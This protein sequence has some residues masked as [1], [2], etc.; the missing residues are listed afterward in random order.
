MSFRVSKSEWRSIEAEKD[1]NAQNMECIP[2]NEGD[3]VQESR[4]QSLVSLLTSS[5]YD[6]FLMLNEHIESVD[7]DSKA[8][9]LAKP[10]GNFLT[11]LFFVTRLLQDNLIQPNI[12]NIGKKHDSFD[13]SKSKILQDVEFWS[14]TA[15]TEISD[16]HLDWYWELLGFMNIL[17][18][19]S[20][21]IL[22]LAN[23]LIS[24]KFLH[25][26]YQVYSLFYCQSR[27]RSKNVTK[28]SLNDL[29]YRSLHDISRGSLWYMVKAMFWHKKIK[30][31]EQPLGKCYYDLRKWAPG[32]FC[33][34]LFST[35]SPICLIFLTVMDV[36]F[37]A[38]LPVLAHQYI[39]FLLIY[40][41]YEDRLDD[42]A[43]LSEANHAE[44]YE[45]IIK[46]KSAVKTQDAMVDATPYGGRSAVFFPSFTTTRSHIFQTHTVLGDVITERYNPATDVFEDVETTNVARNYVSR[47]SIHLQDRTPREKVI[48]GASVRPMFWSRQP[49]PSKNGTPSK[50]LHNKAS[51]TSAPLTPNL[52]PLNGADVSMM[53]NTFGMMNRTGSTNH[54]M[55]I[56][57]S[58]NNSRIRRNST[59]PIKPV[60]YMSAAGL[61]NIHRPV[62]EGDTSI[63][64]SIDGT[65]TELPFEEVVRRGRRTHIDSRF[66]RDAPVGRSSA[67]SSRHS[68]ISPI[69]GGN[70]SFRGDV[71]DTRPPFR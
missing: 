69:K 21:C 45:K 60:G 15:T 58:I 12:H 35:F 17:L 28:R 53:N 39:S 64:F 26:R 54:D 20:C 61:R 5:P 10:I 50:F 47:D 48:N 62:M 52:K 24:Y 2:E 56:S 40:E 44:I 43:C 46:P 51:P 31:P 1:Q 34:A 18:Q 19:F 49:S 63:S 57:R 70:H 29:G 65:H 36:S 67:A 55:C 13:L 42:E 6:V 23:M 41:R 14:H 16:R 4:L 11:M 68:S 30:G 7:W 38:A 27:P 32:K 66:T 37:F 22:L 25:A 3:E 33:A 71:S 9:T 8:E 59:S